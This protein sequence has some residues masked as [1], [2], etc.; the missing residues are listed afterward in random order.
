MMVNDQKN[1]VLRINNKDYISLTNQ[2]GMQIV[3]KLN[4]GKFKSH[5]FETFESEANK[6]SNIFFKFYYFL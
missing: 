2:H 1:N 4:N 3:K 6:K 5:E